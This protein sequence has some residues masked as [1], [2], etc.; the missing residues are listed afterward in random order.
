LRK[1][2]ALCERKEDRPPAVA[3][4][5]EK[6]RARSEKTYSALPVS[7]PDPDDGALSLV[8]VEK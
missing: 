1:R 4:M 8:S 2:N 6:D 7:S 5:L 3:F